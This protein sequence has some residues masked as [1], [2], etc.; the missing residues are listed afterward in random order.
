MNLETAQRVL[1]NEDGL[2]YRITHIIR[3]DLDPIDGSRKESIEYSVLI[4]K[5][6]APIVLECGDDLETV[7]ESSI[8]RI[9]GMEPIDK[10]IKDIKQFVAET[11]AEIEKDTKTPCQIIPMEELL[12]TR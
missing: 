3:S 2:S 1:N 5:D 6:K 7:V 11:E 8:Q 9:R 4:F 10:T 12:K